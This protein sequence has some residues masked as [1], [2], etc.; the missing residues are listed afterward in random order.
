MVVITYCVEYA[1]SQK[2]VCLKCNKVIPNKSLRVGRMER[3]S[4]KEKKK[5]AKFRWYHFKCFEVPEILTK[6]PVHL[7]RGQVNLLDKDKLRLEKVIKLGV[8]ASW[9]QIVDQH[10]KKAKED[11]EAAAAEALENGTPLPPKP[12]KDDLMDSDDDEANVKD[13]TSQL[14]GEVDR[15]QERKNRKINKLKAKTDGAKVTKKQPA[16][17]KGASSG[18]KNNKDTKP[19]SAVAQAIAATRADSQKKMELM[20]NKFGKK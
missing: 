20:K 6:I 12:S 8:G 11:E 15:K 18:T 19:M 2:S 9:S 16:G 3:T 14:T 1:E 10:K 4:E 13:F 5:F 7:I 17:N